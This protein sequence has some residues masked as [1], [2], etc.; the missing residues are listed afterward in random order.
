MFS[1]IVGVLLGWSVL[2]W[3]MTSCLEN[4][5]FDA[6]KIKKKQNKT[7]KFQT[8]CF[9][10]LISDT[11]EL[12]A[13]LFWGGSQYIVSACDPGLRGLAGIVHSCSQSPACLSHTAT[14]TGREEKVLVPR[15]NESSGN[16]HF[17]MTE[18]CP[19]GIT[20]QSASVAHA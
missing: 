13:S 14:A 2:N 8:F 15:E 11:D 18:F 16:N 19:S 6:L 20:A 7:N 5:L 9:G 17:E 12:N 4:Q 3:L 1:R 10:V